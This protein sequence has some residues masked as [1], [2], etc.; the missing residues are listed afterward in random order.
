MPNPQYMKSQMA[1]EVMVDCERLGRFEEELS[2]FGGLGDVNTVLPSNLR[3]S[4]DKYLQEVEQDTR[5]NFSRRPITHDGWS[6]ILD[7]PF[8]L[9]S[10]TL[11]KT[12]EVPFGGRNK[13]E[14]IMRSMSGFVAGSF[15]SV[16]TTRDSHGM[17]TDQLDTLCDSDNRPSA[18]EL[19]VLVWQIKQAMRSEQR[20]HEKVCSC[21]IEGLLSYNYPRICIIF[22]SSGKVRVLSASHSDKLYVQTSPLLDFGWL[23]AKEST[24]SKPINALNERRYLEIMGVLVKWIWPITTEEPYPKAFTMCQ[25]RCEMYFG[26]PE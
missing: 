3:R 14:E 25:P 21:K 5:V 8:R 19:S 16:T 17:C 9:L 23:A 22:D 4:M 26:Q 13:H 20:S 2:C 12:A 24:K 7:Y 1:K 10:Q 18:G 6:I 11:V 15:A